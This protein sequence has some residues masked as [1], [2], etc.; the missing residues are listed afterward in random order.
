VLEHG[1]K[2]LGEWTMTDEPT[3]Q[4]IADRIVAAFHPLRIILFGSR[5]RGDA[6]PDSDIDLLVEMESDLPAAERI[7]A[8]DRL[9]TPRVWPMDVVVFTPEEAARQRESRNSLIQTAE[10]EGKVVYERSG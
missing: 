4:Q 8:V 7:R 6:R 1:G 10:R 9:F 3:V 2:N 5:A